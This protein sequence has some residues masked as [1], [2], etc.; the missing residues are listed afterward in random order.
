MA[1]GAIVSGPGG[2]SS[3]YEKGRI[4]PYVVLVCIVGACTGLVFG[5]D[6]GIA[7][8]VI[9]FPD[10]Q[11]NFFPNVAAHKDTGDSAYC[12]YN[13]ALLQL[14]VSVLFLAGI[15]GAVFG[16][17][18]NN[19]WGRKPTMIMGGIFFF[20]GAVV[21]APA[22]HVSML[23]I[24]RVLLGLGV[25]CCV[26]CGPL[27]L[28]ELAPYHLRGAFNVQFQLFITIGIL[29]AQCINYGTQFISW[30]WRLSLGL[31]AVPALM[32]MVGCLFVPET[33]NSLVE[34]GQHEKARRN[35]EKIRGIANVDVEFEDIQEA[36]RFA[37][38]IKKN[39]W[40][41]M[42]SKRY[43]PQ[44]VVCIALP[45]FNQLDGINSIMFYAPQLF[46]TMGSGQKQALLTHVIIGV[47]NVV[48][49]LVAVFT[50]DSLG[51]TFWLME[52]SFHMMLCEIVV[53]VIIA[54]QMGPDGSLP[55]AATVGLIIVVCVF[56]AGHAWG[57][58]PMAWLVCS[59]VQPLHTRAAGTAL[60][61]VSNFLLTF[62]IGQFFLSM[63]CA[64]KWGVFLFFAGWLAIMGIFT[65]LF[66]PETKGVPI[67]AIEE[68]LF[69]KHWFWGKIIA[70][71]V[72]PEND[73][74]LREG[75]DDL[76]RERDATKATISLPNMQ[77]K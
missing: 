28:S 61:T 49:T 1:G 76:A 6:I 65:Y 43:I 69:M 33:P 70:R 24:G 50:V 10:F 5:Y 12:K 2:R 73:P 58:G 66:V 42:F 35:L 52:A 31:A 57:W 67:E 77:A 64:M 4:T 55:Y 47:V 36:A 37:S 8:G 3:H 30:G 56:I 40:R 60:A 54:T 16:S 29:V 9:S 18:T 14:F 62:I 23:V 72:G 27:F 26:Q 51:R 38:S 22:V 7:G 53:G 71:H 25:G 21:M 48:T 11:E 34:R 44:V 74:R 68:Q 19:K 46:Q 39:Q 59:E 32:L 45:I 75:E 41:A 13:D 15:V 20:A 63:L 17:Y